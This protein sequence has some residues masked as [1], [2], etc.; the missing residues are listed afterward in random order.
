LGRRCHARCKRRCAQH[1][2]AQNG[3]QDDYLFITRP[4]EL[5]LVLGRDR[6]WAGP[7][8]LVDGVI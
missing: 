8:D 7:C 5:G 3:I 2:C 6:G 1:D 4:G